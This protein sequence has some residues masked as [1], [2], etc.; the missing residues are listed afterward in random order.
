VQSLAGNINVAKTTLS[1]PHPYLDGM[2]EEWISQHSSNWKNKTIITYAVFDRKSKELLGTVGFVGINKSK[3]ELGYWFGKQHWDKGYCTEATKALIKFAHANLG[4]SRV[5][6]EHLS[7]NPA[8]GRVMK[9]LGMRY[10]ASKYAADRNGNRAK[11]EVYEL[12][13]T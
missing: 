12:Q 10:T 3:A 5:T 13:I 9:K 4:I 7:S 2:A 1:V 6:G 8:S 11:L